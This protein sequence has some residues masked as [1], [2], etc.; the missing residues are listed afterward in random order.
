M[1]ATHRIAAGTTQRP[2]G[3][4]EQPALRGMLMEQ[5]EFRIEQLAQLHH[6]GAD[7]PLS[8]ADPEVYRSLEAGARAA[9]R[10]VQAALWRMDEGTYGRCTQCGGQVEAVRLEILPQ[11]TR[12]L[13]C[14][15]RD[16]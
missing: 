9:L 4:D 12:C 11:T 13:P 6:L 7:A 2:I 15:Q 14:T 8:S 3:A 16:R 10:D 1:Q 5:R